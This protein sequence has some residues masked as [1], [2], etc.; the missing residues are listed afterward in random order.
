MTRSS[1]PGKAPAG[2][3]HQEI[4]EFLELVS[5]LGLEEMEVET[6][7]FRLHIV[8]RRPAPVAAVAAAPVARSAEAEAGSAAP[9][10]AAPAP[11]PAPAAP[12]DETAKY[13]KV[14]APMIGTFYNSPAPDA[15]PF[16][17]IGDAVDESSVL[18]IIEA[19]KLMNE[20]KAE[21]RGVIRKV[22]VENGQPVEY[23]QPIFL[24]EPN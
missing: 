7:D 9:A 12:V 8:G 11:D 1:S 5:R 3:T 24:I 21:T 18:C 2:Y 19:M 10:P 20:I 23:G 13:T 16:V 17:S 15:P 14:T 22:L 6:E 4:K